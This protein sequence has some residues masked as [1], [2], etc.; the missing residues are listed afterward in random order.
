MGR[1]QGMYANIGRVILAGGT[2]FVD[3][4]DIKPPPIYYLYALSIGLFGVNSP[5]IRALDLLFVP[6]GLLGLYL[7]G[8]RLASRKLGLMAALLFGV[9]YFNDGFQNLSQS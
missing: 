2:P 1:D 9:F 7:L 5:A 8:S 6:L 3:M 4:W